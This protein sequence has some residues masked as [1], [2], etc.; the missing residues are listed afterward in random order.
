[1]KRP[2]VQQRYL[3]TAQAAAY[4]GV[5]PGHLVNLRT[6]GLGPTYAC[7]GRSVRYDLSDLDSFMADRKQAS[8]PSRQAQTEG[9]Q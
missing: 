7:F 4:L 6:Q 1:M 2:S 8:K 9:R 5:S 3:T